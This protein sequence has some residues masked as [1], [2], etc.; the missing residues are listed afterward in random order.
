MT[1]KEKAGKWVECAEPCIRIYEQPVASDEKSAQPTAEPVS[2]LK[3]GDDKIRVIIDDIDIEF[4][5]LVGFLLKFWFAALIVGIPIAM[6]LTH[7]L[8]DY[9]KFI[10]GEPYE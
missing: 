5:D 9:L 10:A 2:E 6:L 4:F 7:F 3:Q 1:S 8:R